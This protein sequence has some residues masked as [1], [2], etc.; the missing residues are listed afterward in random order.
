MAA[1]T[2]LP[3][4]PLHP[5]AEPHNRA[6]LAMLERHLSGRIRTGALL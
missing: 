1:F 5:P 4:R 3:D 6:H 2:P